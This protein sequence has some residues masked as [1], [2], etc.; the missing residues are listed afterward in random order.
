MTDGTV[1]HNTAKPIDNSPVYRGEV[2]LAPS[3]EYAFR[4]YENNELYVAGSGFEDE[5]EAACACGDAVP[6]VEFPIRWISI[7]P[8]TLAERVRATNYVLFSLA[9]YWLKHPDN[10]MD[11]KG[12]FELLSHIHDTLNGSTD[13]DGEVTE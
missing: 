5:V 8:P 1:Q 6:D 12:V 7:T 3:G 9:D 10:S 11:S 13:E 4:V 2:Y